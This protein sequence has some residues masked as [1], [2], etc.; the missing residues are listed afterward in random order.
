[1]KKERFPEY[2]PKNATHKKNLQK[3]QIPEKTHENPNVC[4]TKNKSQQIKHLDNFLLIFP[5]L[6]Y[7]LAIDER[8]NGFK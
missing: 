1:L 8:I 5:S 6:N 2:L 7:K 4:T 3:S